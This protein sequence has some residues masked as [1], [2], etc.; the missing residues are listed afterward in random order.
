MPVSPVEPVVVPVKG[1]LTIREAP[2]LRDSLLA[3]IR[4]GAAVVVVDL[5]HVT[6]LDQSAV[7]VLIGARQRLVAGG[8]ELRL[9]APQRQVA[10]VLELVSVTETLPTYPTVKA[11]VKQPRRS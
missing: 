3:A 1:E 11:A 10:R 5:E 2:A 8:G 7:G 4:A 6:F 9:A